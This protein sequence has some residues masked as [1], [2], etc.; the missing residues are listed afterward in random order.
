VGAEAFARVPYTK[1]KDLVLKLTFDK[2]YTE[3][4]TLPAYEVL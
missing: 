1:A 4:L 2:N 3:F